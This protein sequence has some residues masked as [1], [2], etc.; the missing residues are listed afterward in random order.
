MG[1]IPLRKRE[2]REKRKYCIQTAECV[3][4]NTKFSFSVAACCLECG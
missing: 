2:Q 4:V 3:R 1:A